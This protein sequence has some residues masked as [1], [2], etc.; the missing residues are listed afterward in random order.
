MNKYVYVTY[1]P[2][3]EKVLCVHDKPNMKCRACKKRE[4]DKRDMYQLEEKRF[5]VKTK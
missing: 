2:L 1:D 5:L 3:Y 4:Y